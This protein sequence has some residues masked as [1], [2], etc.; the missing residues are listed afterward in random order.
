M[1]EEYAELKKVLFSCSTVPMLAQSPKPSSLRSEQ[2][3]WGRGSAALT[4]PA[5]GAL[6]DPGLPP[7]GG[8]ATA[9]P[10]PAPAHES[11]TAEQNLLQHKRIKKKP[12]FTATLQPLLR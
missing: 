8:S 1:M 6:A 12:H 5:A 4:S 2:R 10:P 9:Q 3:G 7:G 11:P